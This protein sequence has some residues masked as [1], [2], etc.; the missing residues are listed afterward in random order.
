MR[1][2]DDLARD[3]LVEQFLSENRLENVYDDPRARATAA[4]GAGAVPDDGATRVGH[5]KDADTRLAEEFRREFLAEAEQ[6]RQLKRAR[7]PAASAGGKTGTDEPK[8][9]KLGGSRQQRAAMHAAQRAAAAN[10]T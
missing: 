2:E 10:P 1:T 7:Q 5:D 4:A 3:A 6:R 9:P 8:G